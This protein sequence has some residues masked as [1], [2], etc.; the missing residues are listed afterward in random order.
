MSFD[1]NF[2]QII[3]SYFIGPKAENL[4]FFKRNVNRIF[5]ELRD[6]RLGYHTLDEKFITEEI[7]NSAPFQ[8]ATKNFEK[9]VAKAAHLLGKHSIPFWSP[10]YQ[11]HMCTD[12]AAPGILG[13]FMTMLYNPNN[14]ALEA[15]PFTTVTELKAGQQLCKMF[16]Y[17]TTK[18][19][20]T[21]AWGHI[22]ADGTIAN[23]ESI[24]VARNLKFYPLAL[25]M[26][27]KEDAL[28]FI[29]D[30]FKVTTC[31][32][33]EK[34]FKDFSVWELLNLKPETVLG[35]PDA[36]RKQFGITGKY[37]E[38]VLDRYNIQTAGKDLLERYFGIDKPIKYFASK[39]RH[40]SWPKG[41]A[42]AGLGSGCVHGIEVDLD[43]HVSLENLE[44]ELNRCLE[45]RQAV[46]AVVAIIG[47]TEEGAVDRLRDIIELR[48]KFQN[49]GLSF[50]VHAD[51]AWGGYFM[52]MIDRSKVFEPVIPK[53]GAPRK[54]TEGFVPS[55]T[56][57]QET[58]Q[59]LLALKHADSI[60]VDPHKAGYIPYP[61]G[62]LCYRDGRMRFLVTWSS[63][64]LSQGSSEN[65]GI[66]GVEGSK[67]G[68][69]AMATWLSNQTIG[70]D[71]NGY[72]RLLGEAAFTSSRLSAHYAAM[73]VDPRNLDKNNNKPYFIC[74]PFN[75]LSSELEGHGLV[76]KTV[77]EERKWIHDN[78]LTMTN[79][80]MAENDQVMQYIRGLGSDTNINAF[81]LNWIGEDGKP[82]S[83]IEEAN[84]FMKNVVD[85]LSVTDTNGK[86][87]AI[88]LYLT[89]TKFEPQLYG[90]CAQH[91][92]ERLGIDKCSQ[93]LMVLRNVVMS[94]FPTDRDFIGE[95]MDYFQE[96]VREEVVRVRKRNHP[97]EYPAE[98]LMRGTDKVFLEHLSS[99]DRATGRQQIILEVSLLDE[100]TKEKYL[101]TR[102]KYLALKEKHHPTAHIVLRSSK[103][104]DLQKVVENYETFDGK[105]SIRMEDTK[106]ERDSSKS[107]YKDT[108][109]FDARVSIKKIVIS[110]PLNSA[111]RD[112]EYPQQFMPFYLYGTESE[113][114][115]SH[116]L[117][118]S[119]NISLSAG[120]IELESELAKS[121]K[122]HLSD[123]RNR[124]SGLILALTNAREACM[125]P[126][127]ENN[128]DLPGQIFFQSGQTYDVKVYYDPQQDPWAEGPGLL[129]QLGSPLAQG[130]MK[131]SRDVFVDVEYLRA[132]PFKN[133]KPKPET[134]WEDKLDEIKAVLGGQGSSSS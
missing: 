69:A 68:A 8:N 70:L 19:Q 28:W 7:Q 12:L 98:F 49:K 81:A 121:I 114:H 55:L 125:H 112:L 132:D 87:A 120:E 77:D 37:L 110:R 101:S 14:V 5:D 64:Y 62:S 17:N 22:T 13:Y 127:P 111:N 71:P 79:K 105:I 99:F 24:W 108:D 54:K 33:D 80:E 48:K 27:I 23:L 38:G 85:R 115:I 21:L 47:S 44:Q 35:L 130:R 91:F 78:I 9:A 103:S 39:T 118:K 15:S 74:I 42:I 86:P 96:V 97:G 25:Y 72:G 2:H 63:P 88:P 16:G 26:A 134:N 40:Y 102:A 6:T 106:K 124:D 18:K 41:A 53:I 129:D 133:P 34:P 50:L 20:D 11:G 76:F 122:Q 123:A 60:T 1:K 43:G 94:P 30:S 113:H 57:K 95:L 52:S 128:K 92:M 93:D 84:Y 107:V 3:S 32:G 10:R 51:A 4:E 45:E 75:R 100:E 59:D 83:D 36:L 117:L 104:I 109:E 89:S 90:K 126:F 82:N 46:Y 61:A 29:A 119:P 56:L 73:H 31:L 65:I 131:L 66:Y 116:M 58:E 67:P